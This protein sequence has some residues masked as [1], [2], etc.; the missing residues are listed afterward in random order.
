MS[1]SSYGV[2]NHPDILTSKL[3]GENDQVIYPIPHPP[4]H[5]NTFPAN[6]KEK[7]PCNV[8]IAGSLDVCKLNATSSKVFW[9]SFSTCQFF[10]HTSH[11]SI[12]ILCHCLL[13][14]GIDSTS[15]RMTLI[16]SQSIAEVSLMM[17]RASLLIAP[18]IYHWSLRAIWCLWKFSI[19]A[20]YLREPNKKEQGKTDCILIGLGMQLHNHLSHWNHNLLLVCL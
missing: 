10:L 11:L 14:L 12:N 3:K 5:T 4:Q 9:F 6:Y 19:A 20:K 1:L 7:Q 2:G 8:P 16:I 13:N 17:T 15:L 18:V